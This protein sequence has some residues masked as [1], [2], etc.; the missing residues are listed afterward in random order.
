MS[1][2]YKTWTEDCPYCGVACDAD[3]V[4]IGIGMQQCGP[5]HCDQCGA[6]QI[7]PHDNPRELSQAEKDKG[8]YAPDSEPGSTANVIHGKIVS[9]Q[10]MRSEY[11]KEFRDNPLW[12]DKSYVDEWW[13]E[14]RK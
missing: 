7:G 4:D 10:Q 5:F 6:S 14:I 2:A 3:F 11:Q 8:W 13:E 1:S 12:H 9:H